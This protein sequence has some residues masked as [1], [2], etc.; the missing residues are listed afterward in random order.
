MTEELNFSEILNQFMDDLDNGVTPRV[1]ELMASDPDV[2]ADLVPLL[3]LI[4]LAR[5]STAQIPDAQKQSMKSHLLD[6]INAKP[7]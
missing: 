7:R 6:L 2:I 4:T 1:Y 5:A 3:D